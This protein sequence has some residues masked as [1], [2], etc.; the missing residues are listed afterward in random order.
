MIDLIKKIDSSLEYINILGP[1]SE[2]VYKIKKDGLIYVLKFSR[3]WAKEIINENEPEILELAKDTKGIT[4]LVRRYKDFK[5]YKNILLKE[6]YEGF[7]VKKIKDRKIQ[8]KLK[9]TVN[10]LHFLGIARLDLEDYNIVL[11][12]DK[13]D[14]CIVDVGHGILKRQVSLS[15]F[16]KL[17]RM[18]FRDLEEN[19]FC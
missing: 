19:I 16:E 5:N 9:N 11:S 6:Y 2:L 17:K 1:S 10:N 7:R 12:L 18:D 15:K 13:K 14:V 3:A 8:D 4:H